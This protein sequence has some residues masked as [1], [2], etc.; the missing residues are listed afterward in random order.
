MNIAWWVQRWADLNPDKPAIIFEGE[1]ITYSD[2]FR[3]EPAGQSSRLLA[4]VSGDRKGRSGRHDI[5]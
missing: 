2:V 4:T 3:T 1:E 5:E